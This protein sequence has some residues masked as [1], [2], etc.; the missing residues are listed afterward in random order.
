MTSSHE[1][2][3]GSPA[4][5]RN[6]SSDRWPHGRTSIKPEKHP[7]QA[8][9]TN[10]DLD[11]NSDAV[12]EDVATTRSIELLVDG[13]LSASG[14]AQLVD[15][16][17]AEPTRWK[18]VA[19]RFVEE[20]AWRSAAKM[21]I[22]SGPKWACT[23]LP[24]LPTATVASPALAKEAALVSVPVSVPA[25]GA[26]RSTGHVATLSRGSSDETSAT[27]QRANRLVT[28]QRTLIVALY[29]AA[30]VWAGVWIGATHSTTVPG[31]NGR[32]AT[33][34]AGD[35][36]T[37]PPGEMT[38]LA[39]SRGS[40]TLPVS[41][42]VVSDPVSARPDPADSAVSREDPVVS[43]VLVD[44]EGRLIDLSHV[45]VVNVRTE[46]DWDQLGRP[47]TTAEL[48][49]Q[50][51]RHGQRV[52]ERQQWI[53]VRSLDGATGLLA[54]RDVVVRPATLDDYR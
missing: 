3:G 23:P 36:A 20:Q 14:L 11:S 2:G 39:P 8:D 51:I 46:D 47:W 48:R 12:A 21:S 6:S 38:D 30:M 31:D 4:D 13:E 22:A 17:D 43:S 27:A 33:P 25:L 16:C 28:P 29:S 35:A 9:D 45:P 19:L 1:R 54:V 10:A 7:L 49:E 15:W 5:N 44:A 18:S 24:G 40:S 50:F 32:S 42:A 37:T 26:A 41:A 53:P 52:E 34:I